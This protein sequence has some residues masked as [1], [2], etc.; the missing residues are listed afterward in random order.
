MSILR[1]LPAYALLL[2]LLAAPAL[3]LAHSGVTAT[4]PADGAAL[5]E[6][7]ASIAVRFD[8]P[9]RIT[10]FVLEGAD[11]EV[12]LADRPDGQPNDRF[13][14]APDG[15]LPAGD[16]RVSWRALAADG[17]VMSGAFSFSVR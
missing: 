6:A 17:H 11:G 5:D 2:A 9:V 16:Y 7:P 1:S 3:L 12:P 13:E 10:R 8:A 14:S 15:A 4:V